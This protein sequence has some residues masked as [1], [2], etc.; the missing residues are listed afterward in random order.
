MLRIEV[1]H[2]FLPLLPVKNPYSTKQKT[3]IMLF[4]WSL[5]LLINSICL[6]FIREAKK[7]LNKRLVEMYI[8]LMAS[9]KK[10]MLRIKRGRG[11]N[12]D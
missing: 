6:D 8:I 11:P 1:T 9:S 2:L 10:M 5:H 12:K 4:R 7:A 3:F